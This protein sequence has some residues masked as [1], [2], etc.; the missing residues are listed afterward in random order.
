MF[1]D[2][3]LKKAMLNLINSY[4]HIGWNI[5]L[6][7]EHAGW[8]DAWAPPVQSPSAPPLIGPSLAS[9]ADSKA[10]KNCNLPCV[11]FCNWN[12]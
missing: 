4:G 2:S 1:G 8:D 3:V 5:S 11:F 9:L 6:Q 10:T 7:I 12:P